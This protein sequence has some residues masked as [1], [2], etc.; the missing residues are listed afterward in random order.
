MSTYQEKFTRMISMKDREAAQEIMSESKRM[1]N[2]EDW[3]IAYIIAEGDFYF[4]EEITPE[5]VAR[6]CAEKAEASLFEL[7]VA[8]QTILEKYGEFFILDKDRVQIRRPLPSLPQEELKRV[9][10]GVCDGQIFT[11]AHLRDHDLLDMVFMPVIFGGLTGV[12]LDSIGILYEDISKAGPRSINGLPNFFSFRLMNVGDWERCRK[13]I[14]REQER[15]EDF[16]I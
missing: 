14:A 12:E 1:N 3:L 2:L 11:S 16:E 9:V 15:R 4:T 13:A 8:Y 7:A 10:M 5:S 6:E